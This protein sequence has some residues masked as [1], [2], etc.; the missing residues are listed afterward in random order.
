V[1][2]QVAKRAE[3][4]GKRGGKRKV[5][6]RGESGDLVRDKTSG[7]EVGTIA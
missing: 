2:N 3:E 6:E 4:E 1:E 5:R 7:G